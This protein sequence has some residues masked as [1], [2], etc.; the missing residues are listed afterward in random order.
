MGNELGS[1]NYYFAGTYKRSGMG[2][3]LVVYFRMEYVCILQP[4]QG[5]DILRL[6]CY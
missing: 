2:V 4:L 1:I 3:G 5:C 6:A